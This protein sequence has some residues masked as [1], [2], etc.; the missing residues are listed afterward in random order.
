M[1]YWYTA[2]SFW[3][4]TFLAILLRENNPMLDT[5][6][7]NLKSTHDTLRSG[8]PFPNTQ[9]MV[10][11][12]YIYHNIYLAKSL[13]FTNLG[14]CPK[15]P[16]SVRSCEVAIIWPDLCQFKVNNTSLTVDD[17]KKVA[18]WV[19]DPWHQGHDIEAFEYELRSWWFHPIWNILVKLDHFPKH[20]GW[21]FQKYLSCHQLVNTWDLSYTRKK[22]IA[23][24]TFHWIL[25]V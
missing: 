25:V 22:L 18:P 14:S 13:Y 15:P 5:A 4:M 8:S 16:F 1:I 9:C 24:Y 23:G 7:S 3:P 20:S 6:V 21:K 12:P 17:P 2:W 10:N 19:P 11:F